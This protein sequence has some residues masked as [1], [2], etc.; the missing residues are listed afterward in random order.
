MFAFVSVSGFTFK[1]I[2]IANDKGSILDVFEI[3]HWQDPEKV[4]R[5]KFMDLPLL[6]PND[7]RVKMALEEYSA[8][9]DITPSGSE[10]RRRGLW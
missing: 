10:Y 1:I 8:G 7:H 3:K 9:Y 5:S 6:E 2:T 4:L